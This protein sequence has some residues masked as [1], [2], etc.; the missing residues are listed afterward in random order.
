MQ[1]EKRLARIA[2]VLE[3][4]LEDGAVAAGIRERKP[5]RHADQVYLGVGL[6][7]DVDHVRTVAPPS[8]PDVDDHGVG[9]EAR[10]ESCDEAPPVG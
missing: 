3:D 8:T 6:D 9:R 5:L 1:L 7:V 10:H 2:N 4:C